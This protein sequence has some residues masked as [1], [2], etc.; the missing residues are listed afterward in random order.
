MIL[1]FKLQGQGDG[2]VDKEW[3][4]DIDN[5]QN[6]DNEISEFLPKL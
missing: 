2:L 6:F 4:S 1:N 3:E 5:L